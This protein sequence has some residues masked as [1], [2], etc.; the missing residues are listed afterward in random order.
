MF[1][2]PANDSNSLWFKPANHKDHLVLFET[3]IDGG[4]EFD[5]MSGKDREYR[6][7][8]YYDLDSEAVLIE[9]K[10]THGGIVKKLAVGS[11]MILGRIEQVKTSNGYL[12]WV[13]SAYTPE[14]EAQAKAWINAG[15]P[16][17]VDP[18][19]KLE[20][21]AETAGVTPEMLAALKRLSA[22]GDDPKF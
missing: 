3:V 10:V 11:G 13:L 17:K 16:S 8:K 5:Q 2:Q 15:K 22:T 9:A 4:T 1:N 7:V 14:D 21:D 6:N 19:A 12:A 20:R 18:M